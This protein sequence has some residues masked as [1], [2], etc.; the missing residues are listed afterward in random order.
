MKI[1]IEPYK[2]W[3]GGAKRLGLRAGILRATKKQV[4]RHGDFTH[5][6]NWGRSERRFNGEYINNPEAVAVAS[7][8]LESAKCLGAAGV[9]QPDYTE[10]R[11]VAQQWLDDGHSVVARKLLRAN[12]GRGIVLVSPEDDEGLPTAPLYT[13]YIAKTTEFRLHVFN[14]TV[15][16][17][18]EKRRNRDVPDEKVDWQ[19]RN[20]SAGFVFCRDDVQVPD[21]CTSAAVAAVT[22]LGLDFGAV[23]V[24]Y[25]AKRDKCRVYEVNTAPGLEGTTL[26]R[27]YEAISDAFPALN[28]GMYAKRRRV[29]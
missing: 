1:R 3:S 8:K 7:N 14:G 12:S 11:A 15:I 27:Y 23:D 18:Q 20:H 24:G 22:A 6:I 4:A 29:A 21:C 25:N 9:T 17:A 26:E 5:I 28:G 16:D 2:M 19:L 13:K 10:D